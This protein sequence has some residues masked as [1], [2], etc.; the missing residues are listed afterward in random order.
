MATRHVTD[1]EVVRAVQSSRLELQG[2][3]PCEL[4]MQWSR[5]TE[6]V[7]RR[8]MERAHERRL[9]NCGVSLES[10][11]LTPKG[12][13]FLA[14]NPLTIRELE[15]RLQRVMRHHLV[16]ADEAAHLRRELRDLWMR[17]I[18]PP[19]Y[20]VGPLRSMLKTIIE[21]ARLGGDL[22]HA[23]IR[24][25]LMDVVLHFDDVPF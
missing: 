6:K 7:C 12:R 18:T 8:A 16:P 19:G 13:T 25:V 21:N 1:A 11:W 5:Q 24:Q 10:P 9:I 20:D 23:E 3:S 17:C 22:R 14:A 4:L 2:R 15:L